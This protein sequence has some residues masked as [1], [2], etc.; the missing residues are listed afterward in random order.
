MQKIPPNLKI[1]FGKAFE[2]SA[3]G[4]FAISSLV[5]IVFGYLG[6]SA[7]GLW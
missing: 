6:G 2:A 5:A 3:T 4:W 7:Y 1:R